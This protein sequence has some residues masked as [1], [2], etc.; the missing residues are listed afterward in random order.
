MLYSSDWIE[1][2]LVLKAISFME[3]MCWWK[4]LIKALRILGP[5][6]S[7]KIS[8]KIRGPEIAIIRVLA[9]GTKRIN[10]DT[11]PDDLRGSSLS[12]KLSYQCHVILN[13]P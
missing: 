12:Y 1:S 13:H 2:Y 8:P 4:N 5:T 7:P 10:F 9:R 6:I 11:F 3:E